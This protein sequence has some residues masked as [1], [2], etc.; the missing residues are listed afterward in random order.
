MTASRTDVRTHRRNKW[1]RELT[2]ATRDGLL[3]S[4]IPNCRRQVSTLTLRS[5]ARNRRRLQI[6]IHGESPANFLLDSRIVAPVFFIF[7]F[8]YL[9]LLPAPPSPAVHPPC[10]A[11]R[12]RD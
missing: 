10:I 7:P 12:I 2:F 3:N 5:L 11:I 8:F 9:A 4:I 6:K 1:A